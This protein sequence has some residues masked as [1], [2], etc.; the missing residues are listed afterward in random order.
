MFNSVGL[1]KQMDKLINLDTQAMKNYYYRLYSQQN[2]PVSNTQEIQDYV[3]AGREVILW[4]K[5]VT[6]YAE[7]CLYLHAL[8]ALTDFMHRKEALEQKYYVFGR[9]ITL[10]LV[11]ICVFCLAVSVVK[12]QAFNLD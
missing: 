12:V 2:L 3:S 6:F 9:Y 1:V 8:R 4:A 5:W 11:Y 10:A 7:W